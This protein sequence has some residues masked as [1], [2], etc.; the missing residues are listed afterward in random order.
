MIVTTG[1]PRL[2]GLVGVDV[3]L[4]LDVGV[5]FADPDHPVAELLDEELRRILVDRLRDGDGS[6]HLEERLDQVRAALRHAVGQLLDGDRL[7]NDDVADL[8]GGRARTAGEPASPSRASGAARRG[9]APGCRP[10][11]KGRG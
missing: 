3:G 7:G 9:C 4:R 11:P 10:R 8:L 5:A 6:A 1:G 2:K